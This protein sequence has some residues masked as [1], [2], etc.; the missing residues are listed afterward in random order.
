MRYGQT[1]TNEQTTLFVA[2]QTTQRKRASIPV[3]KVT[4]VREGGVSCYNQQIRSAVDA[5]TLLHTY[6]ADVDR[7]HFVV[8]M[9]DQ[10]NKVI[11]I[12]TVS[13]GSLTASIV[14][15]R[16]VFKVAILANCASILLAHNHRSGAPR[17][18]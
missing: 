11:G 3:Y 14:H 12:N 6:L 15:P 9:L 7:E 13:I 18:A 8:L 10:K 1:A 5:A 2:E 4:L 16:E 17:S